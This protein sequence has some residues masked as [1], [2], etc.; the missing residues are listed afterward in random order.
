MDADTSQRLV[1]L[2]LQ[3]YQTFAQP[4]SATRQR[5]QP[6][7][8]RLLERIPV[9]ASVLDLGCGNGELWRALA[10]RGQRGAYRGVDF[11][12]GLLQ[13]AVGLANLGDHAGQASFFQADLSGPDWARDLAI[14]PVEV[15][16]A[17]AMLHHLPGA[18]RREQFLR[19]ARGLLKPQGR[20]Y[21]SNWQFLNSERLRARIQPWELIGL[22]PSQVD[23]GD[24]LLDWRQGGYGLRYVHHFSPAELSE[25]AQASGY[26]I[27]ESFYSDGEGGRLSIYQTWELL[28]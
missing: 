3:F 21:L 7:V 4:F 14:S 5:L 23:A 9:E 16:T 19:Q 10:A 11:S 12:P 22:A 1:D 25:L 18:R 28:E 24:Y 6:G 17:L 26:C 8:R 27:L 13:A 20:L 15:A 2:N